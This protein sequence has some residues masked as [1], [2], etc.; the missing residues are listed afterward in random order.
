MDIRMGHI[1]PDHAFLAERLEW[2]FR[3]DQSSMTTKQAVF[4]H[5]VNCINV[6]LILERY[7]N[8]LDGDILPLVSALS[9]VCECAVRDNSLLD[10]IPVKFTNEIVFWELA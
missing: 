2:V 3:F 8:L 1:H 9:N 10:P 4:S 5:L 7:P 6:F